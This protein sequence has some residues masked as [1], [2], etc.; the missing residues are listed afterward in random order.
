ML[1]APERHIRVRTAVVSISC[2][3]SL[4][5]LSCRLL[6]TKNLQLIAVPHIAFF[7]VGVVVLI[8]GTHHRIERTPNNTYCHF[9]GGPFPVYSG[10]G[11]ALIEV[12]TAVLNGMLQVC[13]TW[14]G[15]TNVMSCAQASQRS[16]SFA[17]VESRTGCTILQRDVS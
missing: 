13:V 4:R 2:L 1:S 10:A 7:A 15:G 3:I 17:T 9:V 12:I 16:G 14:N 5:R 8:Y 6:R 11:L